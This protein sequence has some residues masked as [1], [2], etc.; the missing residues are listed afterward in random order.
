METRRLYRSKSSNVL[1]G[2]C[3]GIGEYFNIDPVIV[4]IIWVIVTFMGGAG[5]LAYIIAW[6]VIPLE[7][8]ENDGCGRGCL[9]AILVIIVLGVIIG[10]IGSILAFAIALPFN[11][12]AGVNSLMFS[13]GMF[14]LGVVTPGILT[15]LTLIGFIVTIAII[16]FIIVLIK[17]SN[18]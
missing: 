1:A 9:F 4:R 15:F 13:G 2:V 11:I 8:E 10:L 17:K 14:G 3:G 18:K 16:V 5:V 6:L 7:G 12:I